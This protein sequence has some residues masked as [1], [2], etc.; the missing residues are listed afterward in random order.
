LGHNTLGQNAA[1]PNSLEIK[2]LWKKALHEET[3]SGQNVSEEKLM[4]EMTVRLPM[5]RQEIL[6]IAIH[7]SKQQ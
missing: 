7:R 5:V 4:G 1:T 3:L 6:I 2:C